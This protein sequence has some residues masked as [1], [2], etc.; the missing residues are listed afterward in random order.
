[1]ASRKVVNFCKKIDNAL[2]ATTRLSQILSKQ[3]T[4]KEGVVSLAGRGVASKLVLGKHMIILG[5]VMEAV[6][7]LNNISG[8]VES[9]LES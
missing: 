7:I 1:M 6:T 9:L 8:E 4:L 3:W 5:S 2:K